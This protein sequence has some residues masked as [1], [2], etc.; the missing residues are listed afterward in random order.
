MLGREVLPRSILWL[1]TLR[2][3]EVNQI[4]QD[5]NSQELQAHTHRKLFTVNSSILSLLSSFT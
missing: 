2:L 5:S 3:S 1:R 4:T